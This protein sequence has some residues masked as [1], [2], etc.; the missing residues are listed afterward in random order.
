MDRNYRH[1]ELQNGFA[2]TKLTRRVNLIT[3]VA[4]RIRQMKTVS[5]ELREHIANLKIFLNGFSSLTQEA[6]EKFSMAISGKTLRLPSF[7]QI[8]RPINTVQNTKIS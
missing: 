8:H 5:I 2:T 4:T 6:E 7:K 1:L 3:G